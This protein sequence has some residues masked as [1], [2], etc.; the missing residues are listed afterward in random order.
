MD[1]LLE[2]LKQANIKL[3]VDTRISPCSSN[4]VEGSNY[5]P[6]E[7]NLNVDRGIEVAMQKNSIDYLWIVELGNPQKV[8]PDMS[9]LRQH[10][11]SNDDKWPVNRGLLYLHQ[12]FDH[13]DGN[14]CLLCA[15]KSFSKCHR[16]VIAESFSDRFYNGN[17]NIVSL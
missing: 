16:K 10:I 2:A 8:D 9:V 11:R 14:I 13:F 12:I 15:C 4:L 6:K 7:W 1:S 17:L 5:G 3:L